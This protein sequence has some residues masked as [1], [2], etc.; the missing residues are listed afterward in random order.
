[1][2]EPCA[3]HAADDVTIGAFPRTGVFP[4]AAGDGGD[5]RGQAAHA[6]AVAVEQRRVVAQRRE[7]AAREPA[8]VEV[9]FRMGAI[10][11]A[12]APPQAACRLGG[13]VG[14]ARA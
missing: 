14:V 4:C 9:R 6:A 5:Q 13:V 7:A 2:I 11:G 10:D 3:Q 12:A 8:G 1:M